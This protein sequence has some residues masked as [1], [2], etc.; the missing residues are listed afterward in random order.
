MTTLY[1][2]KHTQVEARQLAG[3]ATEAHSVYSWVES[4]VGSTKP[5]MDYIAGEP[6]PSQGVSIDP[7][8][9]FMLIWTLSGVVQVEPDDWI[10]RDFEGVFYRHTPAIFEMLYEG[11]E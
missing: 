2:K 8:T 4:Y 11:V 10:V 7:A 6:R 3:T 9:G 5:P 1:H